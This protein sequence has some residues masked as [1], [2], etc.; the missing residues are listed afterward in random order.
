MQTKGNKPLKMKT[1]YLISF[2]ATNGTLNG[3]PIKTPAVMVNYRYAEPR[4][5]SFSDAGE[6]LSARIHGDF[7]TW[8]LVKYFVDSATHTELLADQDIL[9]LTTADADVQEDETL[10]EAV[11]NE[12]YLQSELIAIRNF[13]QNKLGMTAQDLNDLDNS[14]TGKRNIMAAIKGKAKNL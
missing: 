8:T 7:A 2:W 14:G 11:L 9:I 12:D 13:A 3:V 6:Q 10:L 4:V 5:C 1:G